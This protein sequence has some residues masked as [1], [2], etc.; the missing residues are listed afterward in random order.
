[1]KSRITAFILV[2]CIFVLTGCS[3]VLLRD[4]RVY[5]RRNSSD[6][7]RVLTPEPELE[8]TGGEDPFDYDKWYNKRNSNGDETDPGAEDFDAS[9]FDTMSIRGWFDGSN[10]PV[11]TLTGGHNWGDCTDEASREYSHKNAPDTEGKGWTISSV[12]YYV[13]RGINPNYSPS[14]A[15]N[16]SLQTT[17]KRNPKLS[18]FYFYRFTGKGGGIQ[19][20]DNYLIVIDTYSKL[21][22]AFSKPVEFSSMGA[23]TKWAAADAEKYNGLMYQF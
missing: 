20:L 14:G 16:T 8:L 13:Y 12:T 15:Y 18:R 17:G 19:A 4:P 5:N 11:Y 10:V 21:I 22:F 23:P 6:D 9:E 3:N 7:A 1:M 2:L